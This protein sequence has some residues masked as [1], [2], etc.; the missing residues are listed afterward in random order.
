MSQLKIFTDELK[1][2]YFILEE[3]DTDELGTHKIIQNDTTLLFVFDTTTG[4]YLENLDGVKRV[5][6]ELSKYVE[7]SGWGKMMEPKLKVYE[8]GLEKLTYYQ[9]EKNIKNILES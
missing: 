8:W 6:K 1:N 9:R 3:L 4:L 2:D 7:S 5:V